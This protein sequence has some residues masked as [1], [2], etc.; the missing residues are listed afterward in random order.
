MGAMFYNQ[1]PISEIMEMTYSE[2]KYW[3]KWH[4]AIQAGW[5]NAVKKKDKK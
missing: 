3:N 4:E 1:Q 2:L 5:K